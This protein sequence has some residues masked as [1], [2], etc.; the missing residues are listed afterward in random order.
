MK[1]DYNRLLYEKMEKEYEEYVST[2]KDMSVDQIIINAYEITTKEDI[3]MMFFDSERPDKEAKAML[4][5]KKPLDYLYQR[6]LKTDSSQMEA[7]WYSVNDAI[8]RI[9]KDKERGA[10]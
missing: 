8:D 6:W 3:L 10:R 9:I 5:L 7:L 4:S 1:K 2:V